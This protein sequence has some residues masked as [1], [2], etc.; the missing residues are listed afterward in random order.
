MNS[1]T[2]VSPAEI[3]TASETA[4]LTRILAGR[5]IERVNSD[6]DGIT[7]MLQLA[8]SDGSRLMAFWGR[9]D[10]NASRHD[11]EKSTVDFVYLGPT[12]YIVAA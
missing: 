6:D 9:D 10:I 12:E 5:T 8:L 7:G 2:K 3:F 4:R 11:D 1:M